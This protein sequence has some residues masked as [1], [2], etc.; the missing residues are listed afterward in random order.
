MMLA[1]KGII[2]RE[3]SQALQESGAGVKVMRASWVRIASS[4]QSWVE[5][6]SEAR[7]ALEAG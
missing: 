5:D 6:S 1:G 7:S 3:N 4:V 2:M